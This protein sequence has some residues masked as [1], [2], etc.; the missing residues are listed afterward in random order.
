MKILNERCPK[1]GGNISIDG[2]TYGT[3]K[4]CLQCGYLRDVEEGE[5][6]KPPTKIRL[7]ESKFFKVVTTLKEKHSD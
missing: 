6:V 2:D 7:P 5:K 3:F 1:C 4:S